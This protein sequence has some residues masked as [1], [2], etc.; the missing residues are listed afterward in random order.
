MNALYMGPGEYETKDY[1]KIGGI[2]SVIYI[3]VL[4]TMTYLFY[5]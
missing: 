1:V 3:V 5:I 2:L 4:V